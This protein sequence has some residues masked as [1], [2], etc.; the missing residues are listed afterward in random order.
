MG[1][2]KYKHMDYKEKLKHPLIEKLLSFDLPK[3]DFV[4]AGS[5]A[6]YFVGIKDLGHDL[7]VIARGEA[8]EKAKQFG[9]MDKAP[10]GSDKVV[11]EGGK[12]EIFSLW[13]GNKEETESIINTGKEIENVKVMWL[14]EVIKYKKYLNREKDILHIKLIEEYLK[15]M[16]R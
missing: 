6:M 14:E 3:D 10:D 4:L 7:D 11:I 2:Y 9:V 8:F 13:I 12:I 5:A 15:K 16:E 1:T